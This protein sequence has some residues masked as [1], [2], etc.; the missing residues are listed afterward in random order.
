MN[1]ITIQ[2]CAEDRARLD[3]LA[4]IMERRVVQAETFLEAQE[5]ETPEPVTEPTV[6]LAQIQQKVV[7]LSAANNGKKKAKV[8]D[9][10]TAYS[11]TVS[12]LTDVPEAWPSIWESLLTL[13]SES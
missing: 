1:A 6:T 7:Q 4:A 5:E 12:G 11:P 10:I 9:I 2:L 13:E 3:R 8:R